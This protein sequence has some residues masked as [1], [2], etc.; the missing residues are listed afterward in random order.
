MSFIKRREIVSAD[1]AAIKVARIELTDAGNRLLAVNKPQEHS[2]P[3]TPATKK[4]ILLFVCGGRGYMD[5][6]KL[7]QAI[8][9][10]ARTYTIVTVLTGSAAGADLMAEA[11]ARRM[12]LPYIGIP[13]R[14]Q[15]NGKAAGPIRNQ[16][17]L[18]YMLRWSDSLK[19]MAIACPGGSGTAH[20]VG[21]LKQHSISVWEL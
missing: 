15:A 21:L 5:R 20:M 7:Q 19:P 4:E 17:M 3:P 16:E 8:E 2:A 1:G 9:A 10:M 11:I 12:E 14:W 6:A 13:A 18:E